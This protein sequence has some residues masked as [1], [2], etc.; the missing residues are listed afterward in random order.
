M[1][2]GVHKTWDWSGSKELLKIAA[3]NCQANSS[4]GLMSVVVAQ[5]VKLVFSFFFSINTF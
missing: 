1:G 2:V 3:V 5:S 4:S